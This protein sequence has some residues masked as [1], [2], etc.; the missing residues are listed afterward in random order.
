MVPGRQAVPAVF[1]HLLVECLQI[2]RQRVHCHHAVRS[3]VPFLA[4]SIAVDL[5]SVTL[6][7]GEVD[8]FAD[9]VIG[10]SLQLHPALGGMHEPASELGAV[11]N[12]KCVMEE[13]GCVS[14]S[15]YGIAVAR[16]RQERSSGDA[17]RHAAYVRLD[18]RQ[19][20]YPL[21]PGRDRLQVADDKMRPIDIS[22]HRRRVIGGNAGLRLRL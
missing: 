1:R 9:E 14:R 7:I 15:P 19:T 21:V 16:Q 3:V 4:R 5:D 2:E 8:R 18:R 22:G 11:R 10:G 12:Q 13:T 17:E 6:R 20:D